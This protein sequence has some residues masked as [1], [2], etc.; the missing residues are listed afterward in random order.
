NPNISKGLPV[1]VQ[2]DI[3]YVEYSI[4]SPRILINM[5]QVME[6]SLNERQIMQNNILSNNKN[7]NLII[8]NEKTKKLTNRVCKILTKHITTQDTQGFIA[9][10]GGSTAILRGN[11]YFAIAHKRDFKHSYHHCGYEFMATPPFSILR[12]GLLR[13]FSEKRI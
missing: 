3:L 1:N 12:Q 5:T 11:T 7:N 6:D 9:V 4:C 8:N 13:K 2:D 10:S